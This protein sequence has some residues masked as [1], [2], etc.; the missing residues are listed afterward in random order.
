M[1]GVATTT[2]TGNS[3]YYP[4]TQPTGTTGYSA[5]GFT[6][7]R[8]ATVTIPVTFLR[9]EVGSSTVSALLPSGNYAVRL[10]TVTYTPT[11]GSSTANDYSNNANYV[12][13][14]FARP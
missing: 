13:A 4:A 9:D 10:N 7:P 14:T 3:V 5:Y 8:N 1:N 2:T 12:T 11:G 6:V